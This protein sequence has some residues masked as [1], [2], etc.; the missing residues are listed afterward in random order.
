MFKRKTARFGFVFALLLLF[1]GPA[2]A[3]VDYQSDLERLRAGQEEV[4]AI[5]L[6]Q[7]LEALDAADRENAVIRFETFREKTPAELQKIE[8]IENLWNSGHHGAAIEGLRLMTQSGNAPGAA[9]VGWKTPK[10]ST[11]P[12]PIGGGDT[13]VE[14]RGKAEGVNLASHDATGNLFA[15]VRRDDGGS[16]VLLWTINISTDDG[17]TWNETY[18]WHADQIRDLS[19]TA[20]SNYIYIGYVAEDGVGNFSKARIRRCSASDGQ[21]DGSFWWVEVF[22]KGVEI[23][24]VAI[25]S[26]G[27][28]GD[29]ISLLYYFAVLTDASLLCYLSPDD[30]YNWGESTTGIKDALGG[31]DAVCTHGAPQNLAVTYQ[32][33]TLQVA[34]AQPVSGNWTVTLVDMMMPGGS[35]AVS[36]YEDNLVVV[37][38]HFMGNGIRYSASTNGGSSWTSGD[39]VSSP[40]PVYYSP[41]VTARKGGGISVTYQE[42][43]GEPD[44]C[45]HTHCDYGT[46]NWSPPEPYNEIDVITGTDMDIDWI[47]SLSGSDDYG[48]LWI[49]DDSNK[50]TYFDRIDTLVE[51]MSVDCYA[52]YAS[53]GGT[54]NFGLDAGSGN[55]NRNYLVAGSVSGTEPGIPLPGGLATLPLNWDVFT[56]I[57]IGLLNSPV[58]N[59]F[60]GSLDAFGTAT[61]QLNTG[62]VPPEAVG[63]RMYFAFCLSSP[64][65]YASNPVEI[66]FLP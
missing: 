62:P 38:K 63:L 32:H 37:Y 65:D 53:T 26:Q 45:W 35:T 1:C 9:G 46:Y 48:M 5:P 8:E 29:P 56:N 16:S 55:A 49:S 44:T 66:R 7:R 43:T 11:G 27:D 60:M 52:L 14:G 33:I 6:W 28:V 12:G 19:I 40:F 64:F 4:E 34:I 2:W 47:P 13:Q 59:K 23:K 57:V 31:L 58:F 22:D 42:E 3:Q 50:Y 51:P 10:S 54:V 61:A 20:H 39:I 17:L 24:E 41:D 21:I 15:V 30:G 18:A 36:G 25:A